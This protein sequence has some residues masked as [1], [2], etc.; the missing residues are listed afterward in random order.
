MAQFRKKP[1]AIEAV[2]FNGGYESACALA[3]WSGGEPFEDHIVI[4]TLEGNHRADVGDWIIQGVQ[5][6]F[7][8]C[9]PDIFKMTYEPAEQERE[10]QHGWIRTADRLPAVDTQVAVMDERR[11]VSHPDG[12]YLIAIAYRVCR[13]GQ[14]FWSVQ[15]KPGADVLDA[16]TH[17]C[18][19]PPPKEEA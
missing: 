13:R 7:Y 1:V 16:Y 10:Q 4:P 8:P 19:L 3:T 14:E 18:P 5:G 2:Q 11:R 9:K 12:T 6:E 15:G 17:W